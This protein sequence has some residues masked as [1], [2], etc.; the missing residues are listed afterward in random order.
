MKKLILSLFATVVLVSALIVPAGTIF[1]DEPEIVKFVDEAFSPPRWVVKTSDELGTTF[2]VRGAAC[3]PSKHSLSRNIGGL[4]DEWHELDETSGLGWKLLASSPR[5]LRVPFGL[6]NAPAP[7]DRV[8][9]GGFVPQVVAAT[10]WCVSTFSPTPRPESISSCPTSPAEAAF[11]GGFTD[12]WSLLPNTNGTGWVLSATFER[13]LMV[14]NFG[15]ID[16]PS[17]PKG[18][19]ESV[20]T[21]NATFWCLR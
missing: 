8:T 14:P 21:K 5:D 18:R 20:R 4:P 9:T 6:V 1:A 16:T 10:F 12:E 15:G 2:N 13:N 7:F 17:G 3:P 19:G 11:L